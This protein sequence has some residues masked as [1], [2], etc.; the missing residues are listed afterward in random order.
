MRADKVGRD[1]MLCQIVK[2]VAEAQRSRAPIQRLAD[3]VAGRLVPAVIAVALVAF[4]AWAYFGP[5]AAGHVSAEPS[6]ECDQ[7][8][9]RMSAPI[10]PPPVRKLASEPP[11]KISATRRPTITLKLHP[12]HLKLSA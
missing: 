3:Q 5:S 8:C 6:L 7:S 2:M 4:G 1:T 9:A 11:P 12:S 10:T